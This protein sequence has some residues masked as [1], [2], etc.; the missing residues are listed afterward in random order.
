M[1][2]GEQHQSDRG[3]DHPERQRKP[4][5]ESVPEPPRERPGDQADQGPGKQ[6]KP[7]L[8]GAQA[9][10]VVQA[11]A[12]RRLD[13][14][15]HEHECREECESGEE[16]G[17]VRQRD[18]S[19]GEHAH[20][21]ERM[22]HAQLERDPHRQRD[23]CKDQQADGAGGAPAPVL[24]S[25][26]ASR[27]R[28]SISESNSAPGRSSRVGVLIGDSG[29]NANTATAAAATTT[30]AITNSQRHER[31]STIRPESGR[32]SPPAA[33]KTAEMAP[34]RIHYARAETHP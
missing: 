30:A 24:P 15:R 17:R 8:G 32:P 6:D 19:A 2:L 18:D 16:P 23:G 33:P 11:D 5:P 12:P 27:R 1:P 29:T 10:P 34:D 25:L 20:V 21:D 4:E 14:P 31:W 22:V 9:E 7:G 13:E 28:A 26:K 3:Q